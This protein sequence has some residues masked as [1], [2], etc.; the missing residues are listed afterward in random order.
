MRE[1]VKKKVIALMREIIDDDE[2]EIREE[3]NLV[4]ELELSSL[5]ISGLLSDL[6]DEFNVEISDTVLRR[7]IT[8]GNVIDVAMEY[9]GSGSV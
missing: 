9:I 7:M 6:E 8:V 2:I 5:E 4:N 1:E 3:T